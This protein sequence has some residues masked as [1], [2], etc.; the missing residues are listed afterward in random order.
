[1]TDPE[2]ENIKKE[3]HPVE[4]V[5]AAVGA[6]LVKDPPKEVSLQFLDSIKMLFRA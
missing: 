5:A 6:V 3:A 2:T 4:A 1:V